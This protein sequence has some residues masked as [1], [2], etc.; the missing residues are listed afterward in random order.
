[1][2]LE[3]GL[4]SPWHSSMK[5]IGKRGKLGKDAAAFSIPLPLPT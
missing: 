1:M 5:G 3:T 2:A 4:P